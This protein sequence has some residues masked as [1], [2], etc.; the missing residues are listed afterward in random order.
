MSGAVQSGE[1]GLS[2]S[3]FGAASPTADVAG[4][5]D[6]HASTPRQDGRGFFGLSWF[7]ARKPAVRPGAG[8]HDASLDRSMTRAEHAKYVA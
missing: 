2:P 1:D 3:S 4:R 8:E 7:N 5:G 6:K